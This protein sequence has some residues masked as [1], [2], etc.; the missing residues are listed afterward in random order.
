MDLFQRFSSPLFIALFNCMLT[1]SLLSG[2]AALT[3]RTVSVSESDI[4]NKIAKTLNMPITLHNIF[5]VN[6]SNPVLKLDERTGRLNTTIDANI[7]NSLDK[8]LITGK[9]S[10][11]GMPR[12]D[13]ATNTLMLSNTK[14]ENFNVDGINTEFS[15]LVNAFTESFGDELLNE[16]PLYTLKSADLK[17]GNTIY[18][19]T[20]FKVI[21]NRLQVT[22]KAN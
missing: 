17:V 18:T 3:T 6:L 21:G 16:I 7:T 10:V 11:S 4:Q 13:N 5:N 9:L 15:K 19:P 2:C 12:F 22:L 20:E 8:T 14:I 1:I